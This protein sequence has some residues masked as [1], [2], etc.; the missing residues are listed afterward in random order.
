MYSIGTSA[1]ENCSSLQTLIIPESV[2]GFGITVFEGCTNLKIYGIAG[3]R[4]ESHALINNLSFTSIV[5]V[6]FNGKALSFDTPPIFDNDRVLVPFRA[7]F[8]AFG[9]D[10]YWDGETQTVT[11]ETE[12]NLFS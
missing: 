4:A 9:A 7:I 11:A 12:E 5:K 1:F 10:V 6:M 2:K 8:E 3:S